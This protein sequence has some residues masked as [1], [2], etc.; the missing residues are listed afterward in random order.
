M[1][2]KALSVFFAVL[3]MIGTAMAVESDVSVDV[4]PKTVTVAPFEIA[5]YDILVT[6]NGDQETFTVLVEGLPEEWVHLSHSEITVPAGSEGMVYL[7]ITPQEIEETTY[8]FAVTVKG[9]T[10]DVEYASLNI[11]P[12][13]ELK[14]NM[15]N[16]VDSCLCE[17]DDFM[18]TVEN[19]GEFSE[20]ISIQFEGDATGIVEAGVTEFKMESHTTVDIPVTIKKACDNEE[21]G[22]DLQVNVKSKNSYARASEEMVVFKRECYKFELL[23]DEQ[24]TTCAGYE[25]SAQIRIKN[26]GLKDDIYQVEIEKFQYSE[27]IDLEPGET[28]TIEVSIL[29]PE[30]GTYDIPFKVSSDFVGEEGKITLVSEN[31]Y[32]VDLVLDVGELK[33]AAGTGKLT[34]P[35][36]KNLGTRADTFELE[37]DK[38]WVKIKPTS[39]NLE[40]GES[41]DIYVYYSPEYGSFGDFNVKI[42]VFSDRSEDEE[43]VAVNVLQELIDSLV[44]ETTTLTEE[45]TETTAP[46]VE[47]PQIDVNVSEVFDKLT[48]K[49]GGVGENRKLILSI[50]IGALAAIIIIILVYL[51]VMRGS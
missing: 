44:G 12:E 8:E 20:D 16:E 36:V 50:A 24:I 9:Q 28:K 5:D 22:Y 49:V 17:Q 39:I 41:E 27:L 35:T 19:S 37:S 11:I 45:P 18:I 3:L 29:E 33:V 30:V 48:G 21:R 51:V 32:D 15:P 6:N 14:V 31:C 7:F 47:V 23:Y 1:R 13:H 10:Q 46:K 34:K 42:R 2:F 38:D 26:T 40:S 43:N 25:K 4:F